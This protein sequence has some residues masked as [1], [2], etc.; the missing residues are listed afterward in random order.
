MSSHTDLFKS[1]LVDR[2]SLYCIVE[3]VSPQIR[4]TQVC[5]IKAFVWYSYQKKKIKSLPCL[6]SHLADPSSSSIHFP[7]LHIP[8]NSHSFI[9]V[10]VFSSTWGPI[11]SLHNSI[12]APGY[13]GRK[14]FK[15]LWFQS[16]FLLDYSTTKDFPHLESYIS[17]GKCNVLKVFKLVDKIK[18][19]SI[20]K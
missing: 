12:C 4:L 19:K 5:L 7:F 8:F 16:F 15:L 6:H 2:N 17:P 10:V 11:G 3:I 13:N 20:Y 18:K 1:K 14:K 9:P